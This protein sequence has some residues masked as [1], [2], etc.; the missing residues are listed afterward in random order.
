MN[1]M[2][3]GDGYHGPR[4]ANEGYGT[5]LHFT[6]MEAV[7]AWLRDLGWSLRGDR[8][9]GAGTSV[10][11]FK[12]DEAGSVDP[13]SREEERAFFDSS[14]AVGVAKIVPTKTMSNY[15]GI[16]LG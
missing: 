15:I 12:K 14:C 4:R 1:G 9:V 2:F 13:A 6:H 5:V 10:R 8:C 3:A 7:S 11:V 16:T